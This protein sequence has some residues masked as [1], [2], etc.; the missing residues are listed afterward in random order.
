[1]ND[2]RGGVADCA[3]GCRYVEN[4]LQENKLFDYEGLVEGNES[5]KHR[6]RFWTVE[7]CQQRP[8]TWDIVLAVSSHL[9]RALVALLIETCGSSAE[10]ARFC[11]PVGYSSMSYRLS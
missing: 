1:M 2:A 5:Y 4:T 10:M 3:W 11:T 7:L 8:Q 6:L 9:V